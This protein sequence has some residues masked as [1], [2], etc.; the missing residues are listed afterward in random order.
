MD[1]K[2]PVYEIDK[3]LLLSNKIS[4]GDSVI[5][6]GSDFSL[7]L[8]RLVWIPAGGNG[9]SIVLSENDGR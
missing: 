7:G 8:S 1:V 2:R 3:P 4:T 6:W 9:P 5:A